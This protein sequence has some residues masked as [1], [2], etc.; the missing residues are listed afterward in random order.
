M[1][2]VGFP[3]RTLD[4]GLRRMLRQGV[5]GAI[6]FKRNVGDAAET[7]ELCQAVKLVAP[8]PLVIGVDQEGGRVARLRDAPFT[9]LPP[10]RE[11]G[12]RD[13]QALARRVG[14]L[15][16][17]ELRAVGFDW[18]FAPVLD[19]DTNPKNPVIGDRALHTSAEV[20]SR[21][22]VALAQGL[23]EGG[24]ASCGKHFPGHGDTLQDSHLVLP[25]LPHGLERLR[26]VELAPFVAYAR[27]NLAALMTAHVVFEAVD[28]SLPATL[29]RRVMEE[30]LRREVGFQGVVV[31][32]D[33][34][35]KAVADNYPIGEAAVLG[36]LAGVDLFLIC[37][38]EDRQAEAISALVHAVESGRLPRARIEQ[39]HARLDAL[40]A[41]FARPAG[42]ARPVLGSAEHIS[43]AH[44]LA[45]D[46]V[47]ADPTE[48][49]A[50]EH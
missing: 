17:F 3:G 2:M 23:E 40:A 31:S 50:S 45:A 27:A 11:V 29:S 14:R 32:D 34:E 12:R 39:A 7:A 25:R 8:G 46:A 24:V 13:D 44:G 36:A 6:L 41:R 30:I 16:A 22:G 35:M 19:V 43:L 37:H 28:A 20:V 10:M 26:A 47:G 48:R 49:L 5:F 1:L 33:L 42:A 9:R 18:D 15:L 38:R 21:L 4:E